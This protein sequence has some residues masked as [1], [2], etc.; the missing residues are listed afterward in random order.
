MA[1]SN[2]NDLFARLDERTA[3]FQKS[4]D[5]LAQQQRD[6]I[7]E[8]V[9]AIKEHSVDD[10]KRFDS[11]DGRLKVLENWR[12]YILGA[13]AVSGFVFWLFRT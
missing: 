12:W 3:G 5:F 2:R 10:I 7:R 13:I 1:A 9:L 6:G 4:L 8:L 11:H